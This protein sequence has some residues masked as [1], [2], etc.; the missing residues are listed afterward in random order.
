MAKP[1]EDRLVKLPNVNTW[2]K[3][4]LRSASLHWPGRS[5]AIKRARVERGLYQCASCRELFKRK[6]IQA[7]HIEPV[8]SIEKGWTTFDDFIARL[9]CPTEGFRVLCVACHEVVTKLQDEM[10]SYYRQ[11]RKED[12]DKLSMGRRSKNKKSISIPD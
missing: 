1:G 5:E 2:A 4:K 10:R 6:D 12:E 7:D 9:Y 8:V 11:Q 3:T